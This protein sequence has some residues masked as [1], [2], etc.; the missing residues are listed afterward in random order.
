V[1]KI[2]AKNYVIHFSIKSNPK[3]MPKPRTQKKEITKTSNKTFGF[4]AGVINFF[5]NIIR[6]CYE[7]IKTLLQLLE[8]IL[9]FAVDFI[10]ATAKIIQAVGLAF[11]AIFASAF[12]VILSGYFCVKA[13]DLPASE[14]FQEFRETTF[15]T[16]LKAAQPDLEAITAKAQYR[17]E[18]KKLYDN[19]KLS[20]EEKIEKL[21][22]MK[23]ELDRKTEERNKGRLELL[24]LQAEE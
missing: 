7:F 17:A 3:K 10:L 20:K 14:N 13:I 12:L 6:A 21:L 24:I 19:P 18:L 23:E 22:E 15:E 8:K 1:V 2:I 5:H 16:L 9:R 4:F 11:L